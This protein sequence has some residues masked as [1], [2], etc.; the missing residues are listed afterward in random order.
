MVDQDSWTDGLLPIFQDAG[1]NCSDGICGSNSE[2][3]TF[4]D[5]LSYVKIV[6]DE[7]AYWIPPQGYTMR[8][9]NN[10]FTCTVAIT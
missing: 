9:A 7:K 5:K 1:F 6:I 8:V 2:C 4:Y 3:S 10:D